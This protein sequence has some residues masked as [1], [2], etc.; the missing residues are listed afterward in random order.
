MGQTHGITLWFLALNCSS[1]ASCSLFCIFQV[2][3][4]WSVLAA[5]TQFLSLRIWRKHTVTFQE[6]ILAD[7]IFADQDSPS[8]QGHCQCCTLWSWPLPESALGISTSNYPDLEIWLIIFRF[9]L[10]RGPSSILVINDMLILV[11]PC[12]SDLV[13]R[14][15]DPSERSWHLYVKIYWENQQVLQYPQEDLKQCN[16]VKPAKIFE[17]LLCLHGKLNTTSQNFSNML[18]VMTVC[19]QFECPE[20][21]LLQRYQE[22]LVATCHHFC[23]ALVLQNM[24]YFTWHI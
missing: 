14:E 18:L 16:S 13:D 1:R 7:Q 22:L 15:L 24:A 8:E 4:A 19:L 12:F 10:F 6:L 5:P 23:N 9:R 20:F 11:Y 17:M 3:F 2:T 21:P